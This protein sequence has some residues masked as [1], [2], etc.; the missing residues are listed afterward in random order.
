MAENN[1]SNRMTSKV[2]GR[3][4][5]LERVFD[6]PRNLVFSAYSTSENLAAWWGPEGWETKNH[7]FEFV[8]GGVWHYCMRCIDKDQGEYYGQESCGKAVFHEIT[9]PEKIVYTDYFS[10]AD[11]N[12]VEGMPEMVVTVEFEEQG[13]KTNLISKCEFSSIE[14]LQKVVEMG[15]KEGFNSQLNKLDDFLKEHQLRS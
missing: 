9:A 1:N 5:I 11:G 2:D 4:L 13:G 8:P 7:R 3:T 6:A 10:D 15:A 12:A 14:N